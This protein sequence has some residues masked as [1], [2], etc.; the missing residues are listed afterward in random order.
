MSGYKREQHTIKD[1][2][3]IDGIGLH[4]GNEVKIQFKPAPPD[5]GIVFV[6]TDLKGNPKIKAN[7][8]SVV[9][10]NRS[11]TLGN[12]KN[13]IQIQTVEHLMAA[14]YA[15]QIDNIII[16]IDGPEL[17]ALDGSARVYGQLFDSLEIENQSKKRDVIKVKKGFFVKG[18]DSYLGVFPYDGFKVNYL[19]KYNHP[20]IGT[21]YFEYEYSKDSFIKEIMP[22][23]TF[24]FKSEVES[25]KKA[26]LALGGSLDN[27]VLLTEDSTVNKLRFKDEFVR[28]KVLDLVGD[29]YLNGPIQ[30]EVIA[31]RSGHSDNYEINKM[32][33]KI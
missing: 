15:Y 22:A 24:G 29:L 16:E 4:S 7:V 31:I 26:G 14:L 17:P 8:D 10:T 12:K 32:I 27:A 9:S 13:N 25:L 28:H 23:R 3:L 30:C 19:I 33:K 5:T 11:T 6:R 1:T 21:Q 20:L 18:K 2:A